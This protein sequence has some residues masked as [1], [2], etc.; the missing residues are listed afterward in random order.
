MDH[1]APD[2]CT[3]K[4]LMT[5]GSHFVAKFSQTVRKLLKFCTAEVAKPC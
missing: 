4:A 3:K 2:L 5:Q 1:F